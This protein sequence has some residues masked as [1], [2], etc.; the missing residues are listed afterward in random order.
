[1][2]NFDAKLNE[3]ENID[4]GHSRDGTEKFTFLLNSEY[5]RMEEIAERLNPKM[6]SSGLALRA[7][8]PS[9]RDARRRDRIDLPGLS[10]VVDRYMDIQELNGGSLRTAVATGKHLNAFWAGKFSSGGSDGEYIPTPSD[11]LEEDIAAFFHS[12]RQIGEKELTKVE[13]HEKNE[14]ASRRGKVI[15]LLLALAVIAYIAT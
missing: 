5:P 11:K 12:N 10:L 8:K 2:D 15:L 4:A 7:F 13:A 3:L 1:L 14:A 9:H 6:R